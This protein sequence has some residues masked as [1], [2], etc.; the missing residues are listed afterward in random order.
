MGNRDNNPRLVQ[1]AKDLEQACVDSVDIDGVMTKG[2]FAQLA[3]APSRADPV[4]RL[5]SRRP[6]PLHPRQA[7]EPITLR[8]HH[9]VPRS[10]TSSLS[11]LSFRSQ[12]LTS[13]SV[14][15]TDHVREKVV[16]KFLKN[17]PKL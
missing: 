8:Q 11:I 12:K 13:C 1:F 9:G 6:R 17:A 10:V 16:E 3:H 7:D 5:S 4:A 2:A 14:S 15:R